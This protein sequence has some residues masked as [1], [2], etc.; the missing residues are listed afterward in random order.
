M[1]VAADIYRPA[2]IEQLKEL[3]Q[4]LGVPVF[5]LPGANPVEICRQALQSAPANGADGRHL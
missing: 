2:A 5:L 1:L 3:G 4:R